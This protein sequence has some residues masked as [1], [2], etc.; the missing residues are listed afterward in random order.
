MHTELE[1]KENH[2]RRMAQRQG[3]R[4]V[5]SHTRDPR[6]LEY[7][8]YF[9]LGAEEKLPAYTGG[10]RPGA[11]NLGEVE[12]RLLYPLREEPHGRWFSKA[13]LREN[14]VAYE[15]ETSWPTR[16]RRWY[17]EEMIV[18]KADDDGLFY[19]VELASP[20][21]EIQESEPFLYQSADPIWCPRMEQR[22]VTEMKWV[23]VQ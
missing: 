5:K 12:E 15:H 13:W 9:L 14:D 20:L 22:P 16:T 21:T 2:L 10:L 11:M 1:R 3:K 4:L 23:P 19:G 18:F 17:Q 7:G 6:S 8:K